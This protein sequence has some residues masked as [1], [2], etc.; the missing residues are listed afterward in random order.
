MPD[1]PQTTPE[2]RKPYVDES[3]P[4]KKVSGKA[5]T[6]LNLAADAIA[7]TKRA[8]A[9]Q[10]NQVPAL[11][12]TNLNSRARLDV[13]R[14]DACWEY[15]PEA[16]ALKAKHKEADVAARADI[17][18][19]GNC[20]EHAWVAYHYLRE[21]AAGEVINRVSPGYIDHAFVI[22]GDLKKDTDQELAVSDPWVN[23]PVSC[24]WEDHFS[25]GPRDELNPKTMVADGN[26]YK[27][28]IAAGLKLSALGEQ[29]IKRKSDDA[30]TKRE[31]T[32][33]REQ[34]HY[35]DHDDARAAGHEFSYKEE[36]VARAAGSGA[37]P[38][39]EERE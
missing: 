33:N 20:G 17:A 6:R 13:M 18:H 34:N 25:K 11:Q 3:S 38:A 23:A 29:M 14:N 21:H 7:A 37:R 15:T 32:T 24:L 30:T 28:A 8:I 35:W 22:I 12:A 2:Q 1:V 4:E 5:M 39:A 31:T 19:G 16:W 36:G 26:S 27:S 9:H 10:G